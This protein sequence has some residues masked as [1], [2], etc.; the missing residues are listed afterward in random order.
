MIVWLAAFKNIPESLYESAS[1]DG[2]NF[3]QRLFHITIPLSTSMIFYNL[4]TGVIGALQVNT[5]LI[6]SGG[7][8]GRGTFN[9]L[10]FIAIKIY[11]EAFVN[12]SMGYASAI[13]WLLFLFI[14]LLTAL[15]FKTSK[16]VY[17]GEE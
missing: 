11:N 8:S 16:W 10:Y 1:L 3:F 17:Y 7:D 13:A 15:I 2:A 5:T 9:S 6:I 4:V 14:A 12:W